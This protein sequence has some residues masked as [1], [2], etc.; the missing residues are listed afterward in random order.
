MVN[1]DLKTMESYDVKLGGTKIGTVEQNGTFTYKLDPAKVESV[2]VTL[3]DT[4]VTGAYDEETGVITI[5]NAT[6]EVNISVVQ[7]VP[8]TTATPESSNGEATTEP[9]TAPAQGG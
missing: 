1:T 2:T 9:T 8:A 4:A 5:T 7:K 6:G 3:G